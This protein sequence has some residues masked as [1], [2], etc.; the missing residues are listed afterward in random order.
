MSSRP[1][2][3]QRRVQLQTGVSN[4]NAGADFDVFSREMEQF[5]QRQQ[6]RL[7]QAAADDG[8]LAGQ[9]A[10]MAG[11]A[12]TGSR[13]ISG[14]ARD[15]GIIVAQQAALQTELRD[16]I[17]RYQIEHSNDPAAFQARVDGLLQGKRAETMPELLPFVEQRIADY[18]GRAQSQIIARQTQ[19]LEAEALAD[20]GRGVETHVD[21]ARTAAFEGD[22][23]MVE[24]R[25]QE[26]TKMLRE[27]VSSGLM[28]EGEAADLLDEFER[29][30]TAQELVGNFDRL[31]QSEGADAADA[32]IERWQR[33]KPSDVGLTVDDHQAVTRQLIARRN[34]QR[35]LEAD[36][37]A[38][39]SATAS[40]TQRMAS[41]RV[42]GD[43]GVLQAGRPLPAE[44]VRSLVED[45]QV[46][47]D[48]MLMQDLDTALRMQPEIERFSRL[49]TAQ[50]ADELQRIDAALQQQG[51][52]PEQQAMFEALQSTHQRVT[53]AMENDPRGYAI[54]AGMIEPVELDFSSTEALAETIAMQREQ[55]AIGRELMG[56]P[57]P[58]L[59]ADQAD[60]LATAYGQMGNEDR[61]ALLGTI[62][63]GAGDEALRTLEQIDKKGHHS[64]ALLGSM[65]HRGQPML[66]KQIMDGQAVLSQTNVEPKRVD[67]QPELERYF[68]AAMSDPLVVEQRA[69]YE[70][71]AMARYAG[72]KAQAGDLSDAYD[73][74][75][76][77]RALIEVMPT[78]RFNGRRVAVP[79]G[80]SERAFADWQDSWTAAD[81]EDVAGYE[82]DEVFRLVRSRRG[83]LVELDLS[84]GEYGVALDSADPT[85][86]LL[87]LKRNDGSSFVLQMIK[88][89]A[90]GDP[91]GG[92][93]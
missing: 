43:I 40:A 19:E 85:R 48:P 41:D 35:S 25:R 88:T 34:Q 17:T 79:Y 39:E 74:D 58:V 5:S 71:A 93:P 16:T 15:R 46:A 67:Y 87:P 9:Q 59:T 29:E 76:M 32:S 24:A 50:R 37:R 1:P 92:A 66:A 14:R 72:L 3:F 57:L 56:E 45:A 54:S 2:R 18:A 6:F 51:A 4:P 53:R 21:D 64:M 42:R 78:A 44:R 27:G 38:R 89:P 61:V 26:A 31:M 86:G 84:T 52:T 7:D 83:H 33:T 8:F 70:R 68:G 49:P 77:R 22:I 28:S 36:A 47:N 60:A 12:P 90:G 23:A 10:G 80:V 11:E 20:L 91:A 62:T 73:P 65:V 63:A 55:S 30:V 82:A 75:K 13:T 81:F 69:E